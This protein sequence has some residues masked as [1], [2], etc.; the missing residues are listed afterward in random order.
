MTANAHKEL[1]QTHL[2]LQRA[3][4]ENAILQTK[5]RTALIKLT[6]VV[7]TQTYALGDEV[8]AELRST[9][10]ALESIDEMSK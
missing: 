7:S 1:G 2:R 4:V 8:L 5:V 9:I 6:N 3:M 10:S